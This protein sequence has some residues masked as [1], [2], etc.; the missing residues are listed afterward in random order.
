MQTDTMR[1]EASTATGSPAGPLSAGRLGLRIALAAAIIAGLCLLARSPSTGP[2][3]AVPDAPFVPV[4]RAAPAAP[5]LPASRFGLA[6]PG[7]DAVQTAARIDPRT[8]QR[9]DAL[10]RGAFDAIET[11]ALRVTLT[12]ASSPGSTLSDR[13]VSLFVL[14]ARRAAGGPAADLPALAVLRTGTPSR[15]ATKFGAVDT[16]EATIVGAQRRVCTGFVTREAAFRIDGWLCAPLGQPPET[17]TLVC[18]IDALTLDDPADP[19]TSAA[20]AVPANPGCGGGGRVADATG[21][22]GSIGHR[23]RSKK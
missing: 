21:R 5:A 14:I 9:E 20:F 18:L 19:R 10:T 12:R 13:P 23:A 8:G 6:E 2:V 15:V 17:R 4:T 1:G 11:P 3:A 7:L 22:T 16:L